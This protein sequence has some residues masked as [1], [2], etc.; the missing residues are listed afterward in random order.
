MGKSCNR[1][2]SSLPTLPSVLQ[3][4]ERQ[5][6][7]RTSVPAAQRS[8]LKSMVG[9]K[10]KN[11]TKNTKNDGRREVAPYKGVYPHKVQGKKAECYMHVGVREEMVKEF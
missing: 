1:C 6:G 7:P 5:G 2:R 3:V 4:K 8:V 10:K 11:K 9:R